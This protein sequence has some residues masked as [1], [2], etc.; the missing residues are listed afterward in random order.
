[1]SDFK[2]EAAELIGKRIIIGLRNVRK[3][4]EDE[5]SGLW[6]II[7]AVQENG[8]L[9]KVEGGMD[10]PHWM[11]PPDLDAIEEAADSAFQFGE[12]GPIITDIDLEA[13]YVFTEDPSLL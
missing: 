9:L 10:A 8:L 4:Q 11:I 6:G 7:E 13:H 2:E 12:D 5:Y 3:D 1:M